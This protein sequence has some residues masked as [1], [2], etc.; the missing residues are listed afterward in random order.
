MLVCTPD[1][2]GRK[3]CLVKQCHLAVPPGDSWGHL[4]MSELNPKGP[5]MPQRVGVLGSL[6]GIAKGILYN[7]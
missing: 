4:P 7:A 3:I 5:R 2:E 1:H 6:S